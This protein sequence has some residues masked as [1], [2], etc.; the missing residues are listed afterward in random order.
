MFIVGLL[1]VASFTTKPPPLVERNNSDEQIFILFMLFGHQNLYTNPHAR[2]ENKNR[3]SSEKLPSLTSGSVLMYPGTKREIPVPIFTENTIQWRLC[4]PQLFLLMTHSMQASWFLFI[5][6]PVDQGNRK[7]KY[8]REMGYFANS[9][10]QS[11]SNVQQVRRVVTL[12]SS[13]MCPS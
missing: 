7:A 4:V 5:D 12:M 11:V 1:N 8:K 9:M 10:I 2:N 3:V 6:Q 13:H